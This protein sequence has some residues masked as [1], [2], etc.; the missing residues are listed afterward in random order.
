MQKIFKDKQLVVPNDKE[1]LKILYGQKKQQNMSVGNMRGRNLS[2]SQKFLLDS[3]S[4]L[5]RLQDSVLVSPPAH[6]FRAENSISPE[7]VFESQRFMSE[8][9][10]SPENQSE[11]MEIVKNSQNFQKPQSSLSRFHNTK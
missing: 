1:T 9:D 2:P 3:I 5:D 11:R 6:Q 8:D 10:G 4:S 7:Y